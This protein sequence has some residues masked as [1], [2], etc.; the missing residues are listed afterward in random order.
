M[1]NT[2]RYK[3]V[4]VFLSDIR[5]DLPPTLDGILLAH[6]LGRLS[7][8]L[9]L[10][11]LSFFLSRPRKLAGRNYLKEVPLPSGFW[12]GLTNGGNRQ[13]I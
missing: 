7:A 11:S 6:L 1:Q 2:S 12:L 13:D 3:E 5:E 8:C 9:T 10:Q 4:W